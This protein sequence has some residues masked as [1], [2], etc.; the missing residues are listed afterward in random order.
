MLFGTSGKEKV[1]EKDRVALWLL[2]KSKIE[3]LGA[4]QKADAGIKQQRLHYALGLV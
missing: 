3:A 2:V 4:V 1:K